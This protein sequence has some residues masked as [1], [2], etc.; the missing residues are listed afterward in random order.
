[1]TSTD[2][3]APSLTQVPSLPVSGAPSRRRFKRIGGS[4]RC[5]SHVDGPVTGAP[6]ARRIS[7]TVTPGAVS[8]SSNRSPAGSRTPSSVITRWITPGAVSG[9]AQRSRSLGAPCLSVCVQRTTTLAAPAARSMAPPMPRTSAPGTVQLARS[10]L[11]ATCM[12]PST[13]TSIRP[14]RIIANDVAESKHAAPAVAVIVSLPALTRSGSSCPG[15]GYGPTPRIPFSLCSTVSCAGVRKPATSVGSP[16]PRFT[17]P[18]AGSSAAARRAM[19]SRVQGIGHRPGD[20][21]FERLVPSGGGHDP[22]DIHGGGVHGVGIELGHRMLDL[23]DGH[24]RAHRRAGVEVAGGQPIREV[25]EEV[26]VVG[27]HEAEVGLDRVFQDVGTTVDV[28]DLLGRRDLHGHAAGAV[29]PGEPA[30][31]DGRPGPGGGVERADPGPAGPHALG[32]RSLRH[33]V[34]L[35]AAVE[36]LPG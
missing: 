23:R 21:G 14:E 12:A 6:V 2:S 1:M 22:M 20:H 33:K 36:H 4:S 13:A 7:S 17:Y 9:S 15:S 31:R 26:A 25:A 34:D 5:V 11:H 35:D 18:L 27:V 32:Q 24:G 28:P 19:P 10:P 30:Q 29:A 3:R 16:M 8:T